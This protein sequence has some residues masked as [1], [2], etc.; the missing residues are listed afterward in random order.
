MTPPPEGTPWWAWLIGVVLF[1]L[2]GV[3]GLLI[4]NHRN[5]RDVKHEV[6]NSHASN[7][8]EDMDET[9]RIA[10]D[11]AV[12]AKLGAESSHRTERLVADLI[13][14]I[15]AMEHSADRRDLIATKALTGVRDDLDAHLS[16]VP[17]IVERAFAE[18]C[19]K[20][21]PWYRPRWAPPRED[22]TG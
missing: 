2:I 11:A 8:R 3:I 4:T 5:L 12:D 22:V 17:A 19:P 7:L 10:T 18:H 1:A 21:P 20:P 15:R 13:L 9:R 6:K 14:S 16:E